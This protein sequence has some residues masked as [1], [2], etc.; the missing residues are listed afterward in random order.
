MGSLRDDVRLH[1]V[2]IASL[3]VAFVCLS[4]ALLS[5]ENVSRRRRTLGRRE[6]HDGVPAGRGAGCLAPS[7]FRVTRKRGS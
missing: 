2:A 4:A 1:V 6:V 7:T 3:V 5:V